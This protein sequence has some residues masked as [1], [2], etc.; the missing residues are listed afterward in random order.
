MIIL[1]VIV[2][3]LFLF[4]IS[5]S[6]LGGA[7]TKMILAA[8]AVI[9]LCYDFPRKRTAKI[10]KEFTLLVAYALLVSF[11]FLFA[12]FY[13]NTTDYT[14]IGY[15]ISMATWTG[16]AFTSVCMIK[17]VHG[18][19]TVPLSVLYLMG[20]CVMQSVLA[21]L[22]NRYPSVESFCNLLD[23]DLSSNLERNE[24]RLFGV[25]CGYDVAGMR[26]SAVLVA[27]AVIMPKFI[28]KY[29]NSR[30]LII[31]YFLSFS[32][33]S[34]VGSMISRTMTIGIAFALLYILFYAMWMRLKDRVAEVAPL[35][36]WTLIML[37]VSMLI[38]GVLY[39]IDSQFHKNLRFAFE[40]F[41]SLAEKGKWEVH[42]NDVLVSMY[43]W[44]NT[45]KTWIIGDGY[46]YNTNLDPYYVGKEY[47]Y[48]YMA[49]DVG[50][51]RFIFYGGLVCMMAFFLFMC[52]SAE[53]C[54]K[55][56]PDYTLMFVLLLLLQLVIWGKV[57]SDL[58]AVFA[59]FIAMSYYIER[60]TN[61]SERKIT[62]D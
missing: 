43:R 61:D 28:E 7:N 33:I 27:V 23:P 37:L 48:Y 9:I 2:T 13:N 15:V 38:A 49:T 40:G 30:F 19:V 56:F 1:T 39:N 35:W 34:V 58:Y 50:Y 26:M 14:Y 11:A 55:R 52:K 51:I 45:L 42:S 59:I 10:D 3:D 32:L 12:V 47:K 5:P 57:A 46:F 62:V 60:N 44:P 22:I 24:S 36:K 25:G 29:Q 20:V 53:V 8:V 17:H 18:K 16:G 6:F 4:P 54:A 21:I 41:F 31:S